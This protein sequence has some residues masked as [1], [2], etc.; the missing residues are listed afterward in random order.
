MLVDKP[1]YD[2]NPSLGGG[3]EWDN[4]DNLVNQSPDRYNSEIG[5]YNIRVLFGGNNRAPMATI[6]TINLNAGGIS[7]VYGGG[8]AGPSSA[9]A[10]RR[11]LRAGSSSAPRP[12]APWCTANPTR[13]S[14]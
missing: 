9:T 5:R 7:S 2:P 4:Y 10:P 14:L 6:S 1:L 12:S 3:H 11:P 13:V 8:N